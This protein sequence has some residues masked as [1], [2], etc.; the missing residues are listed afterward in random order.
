MIKSAL[1]TARIGLLLGG[2]LPIL[3]LSAPNSASATTYMTGAYGTVICPS[4]ENEGLWYSDGS[5]QGWARWVKSYGYGEEQFGFGVPAWTN[6]HLAAGC[7]GSTSSWAR[8]YYAD[9]YLGST[10]TD[11]FTMDCTRLHSDGTCYAY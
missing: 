1:R 6:A 8:T 2:L 11:Y 9:I 7:G 3:V 4:G 10:P 5:Y